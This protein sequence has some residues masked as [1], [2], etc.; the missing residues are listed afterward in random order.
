MNSDRRLG[1]FPVPHTDLESDRR[2]VRGSEELGKRSE[3]GTETGL[4]ESSIAEGLWFE[5]VV[6]EVLT[7][8]WG[9]FLVL[10]YVFRVFYIDS[11]IRQKSRL[12]YICDSISLRT[13]LKR[14]KGNL[15]SSSDNHKKAS[16]RISFEWLP[17]KTQSKT[18]KKLIIIFA[19]YYLITPS[20]SY[21]LQSFNLHCCVIK[22][23]AAEVT[24]QQL[25]YIKA[26]GKNWK[27]GY[28]D[29]DVPLNFLSFL[30]EDV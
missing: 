11:R 27:T 14:K 7:I 28:V 8:G 29:G 22:L 4:K 18:Q 15:Y 9:A 6:E 26:T 24:Y 23:P 20:S 10:V 2:E 19:I 30:F 3:N 1:L 5:Q 25:R 17:A 12:K 21:N 13:S 16:A